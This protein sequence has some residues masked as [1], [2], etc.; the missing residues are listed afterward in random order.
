MYEDII[1]MKLR[2]ERINAGYSQQKLAELT[3]IDDSLIAKIEV[4][5]RKPD[6]NTIGKLAEFYGVSLDW[7]F[8]LGKKDSKKNS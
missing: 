4:G 3:G 5:R 8:G 2:E 6:V 1:R 7:L